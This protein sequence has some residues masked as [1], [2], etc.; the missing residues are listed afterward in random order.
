M[1]EPIGRREF[2]GR[3]IAG[4][5]AGRLAVDARAAETAATAPAV[6]KPMPHDIVTLG[7]SGVKP[8]RLGIG[9]GMRGW[10]HQSNQT[11][12]GQEKFTA[13]IR[14][15]YDAG[16]RYFDCADMY[17]SHEFIRNAVKGLPREKLTLLSKTFTRDAEGVRKDLERFRKELGTD[18][19]DVFMLHCLTDKEG[20]DWTKTMAGPMD[21]LEEAKQKGWIKA[22][23]CSCHSLNALK[24][25]AKTPWVD[26]DLAR[27][28]PR[29]VKMDGPTDTVVPVLKQ[30]HERGAGLL[31]MKIYGEGTLVKPEEKEESLRFILSQPYV[32][33]FVI[34]FEKPEE[35]DDTIKIWKTIVG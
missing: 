16:I 26:V 19:I 14:H 29:G 17:G 6:R 20:P 1:S 7:K 5:I 25:A 33:A 3:V 4:G 21:V 15:A 35:I 11:R 13:L 22:H 28:N 32:D 9:T 8:S 34:G 10:N 24:T 18:Y 2:M 12:L 23:G 27:L 30:F 31:C